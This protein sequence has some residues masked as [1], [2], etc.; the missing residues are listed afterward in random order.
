MVYMLPVESVDSWATLA[1]MFMTKFGTKVTQEKDQSALRACLF[2]DTS[3]GRKNISP[4]LYQR[5]QNRPIACRPYI[6]KSK[7]S[8]GI[9]GQN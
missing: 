6:E 7:E 4:G 2:K 8:C 5:P 1:R 3:Y 9:N